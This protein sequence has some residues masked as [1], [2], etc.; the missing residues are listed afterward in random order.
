MRIIRRQ[1]TPDALLLRAQYIL[2]DAMGGA[3][4]LLTFRMSEDP[5]ERLLTH[6]LTGHALGTPQDGPQEATLSRLSFSE[7]LGVRYVDYVF[8]DMTRNPLLEVTLE[9]STGTEVYTTHDDSVERIAQG[10][11]RSVM[12]NT[13]AEG[14]GLILAASLHHLNLQFGL[15]LEVLA[16]EGSAEA[17]QPSRA[18][19][20]QGEVMLAL[21]ITGNAILGTVNSDDGTALSTFIPTA[22]H[23]S[24]WVLL[25]ETAASEIALE[26]QELDPF[27]GDPFPPEQDIYPR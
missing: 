1:G 17:E 25:D 23:Q 18:V 3:R 15:H 13:A 27:G 10:L 5:H 21:A 22:E 11:L 9:P 4:H 26:F 2:K 16:F 19:V 7:S 8:D 20:G 12:G 24:T 14:H 6:A